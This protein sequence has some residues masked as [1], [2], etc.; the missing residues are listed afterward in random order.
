MGT[1]AVGIIAK[2]NILKLDGLGA[3]I[4]KIHTGSG[5]TSLALNRRSRKEQTG[6]TDLFLICEGNNQLQS[7]RDPE[8]ERLGHT[9]RSNDADCSKQAANSY[10]RGIR[11]QWDK[12]KHPQFDA[13]MIHNF[14]IA[15]TTDYDQSRLRESFLRLIPDDISAGEKEKVN[16]RSQ[17]DFTSRLAD[18]EGPWHSA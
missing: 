4:P 15:C 9:Y 1:L 5:W 10:I 18:R 13:T 7:N 12:T 2:T 17:D 11:M 8:N 6:L 3:D 16:C 14:A